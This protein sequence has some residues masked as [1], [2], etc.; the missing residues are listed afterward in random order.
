MPDTAGAP[1]PVGLDILLIEDDDAY[2]RL[3]GAQLSAGAASGL[4]YR[5][6]SASTL[7]AGLRHLM[8]YPI[9]LVLL[10]LSLPDS[11]GLETV[12]AVRSEAPD[13]PVVIVTSLADEALAAYAL[14]SGA[15]DYLIKDEIEPGPL[16][17]AVRYAI[18]RHRLQRQLVNLSLTDEL[19][20]LYNRRGFFTH[21]ERQLKLSKRRGQGLLVVLLDLDGL[22]QINDRFG[23]AEG[24]RALAAV[25]DAL[26]ATFR[27]VDIVARIG[28]DEFAVL[29]VDADGDLEG[30]L[31]ARLDKQI[32]AR[33]ARAGAR[34]PL[35]LSVGTA[36]QTMRKPRSIDELLARAD[37]ALYRDKRARITS[38]V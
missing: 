26:S 36:R 20:G 3:V 1:P 37:E 19:T 16:A 21:A 11:Q 29:V 5:L 8:R 14:Q 31:R 10:D 22:K 32:R 12:M 24:D 35:S 9:D 30:V 6:A 33:N 18:E 23:H 15:Q 17:R 38:A 7:A 28:G 34:Y 4:T 2:V 25:A 13:V 27:D